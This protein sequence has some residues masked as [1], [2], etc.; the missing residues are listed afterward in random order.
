M[1]WQTTRNRRRR[2]VD[3]SKTRVV[4]DLSV[5]RPDRLSR[6]SRNVR[7]ELQYLNDPLKLADHV[8]ST[9]RERDEATAMELVRNATSSGMQCVVAWNHLIDFQMHQARVKAALATYNEMKKRGQTPDSHTFT[10]LLR[11]LAQN[12][13]YPAVLTKALSIY[14]SMRAPTA[15]IKPSIIHTNAALK[16]CARARDMDAMWSIA[17]DLPEHGKGAPDAWTWTT[18]LNALR[19]D[20]L[21]S[22]RTSSASSGNS[23]CN[24]V[25][26]AINH[27]RRMWVD[28]V[29]KWKDGK[30][31][32]DENLVCAMGR[33]LLMSDR[34][35]EWDE[36]L[37]LVEQT[38]EIARLVPRLAD[39]TPDQSADA[40]LASSEEPDVTGIAV[41]PEDFGGKLIKPKLPPKQQGN[42]P[43]ARAT[44]IARPSTN[45]ISLVISACTELQN[46][47]AA[48]AYWQLLTDSTSYGIE[49]DL[50]NYAVYL[51]L[52]RIMR[53][54]GEATEL[55]CNDMAPKADM[56]KAVKLFKIALSACA[57]DSNNPNSFGHATRLV[58]EL[59][60]RAADPDPS[61]LL[62]YM[63]L[64]MATHAPENVK[65]A[66]DR[67]G[68]Q[69][70]NLRSMLA[71]GSADDAKM[72]SRQVRE[73]A[74]LMAKHM[75]GGYM[76]LLP[77]EGASKQ[78][79]QLWE[80]EKRTLS[81]FVTRQMAELGRC[82]G[83]KGPRTSGSA[84]K[85]AVKNDVLVGDRMPRLGRLLAV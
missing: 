84:A 36:V 66:M 1:A 20:A 53:S 40:D 61:A 52:L 60:A 68:P 2:K 37:S 19:L 27:G 28:I 22:K 13:Q 81:A 77:M 76:R 8:R 62:T 39:E 31:Q 85:G 57:R 30:I 42:H 51:R 35:R 46:K 55:V 71:Y 69:F 49:P 21:A 3:W 29:G 33:I 82:E 5:Q 50:D 34:P 44:N 47:S 45:T 15:P 65:I 4:T 10:I 24:V 58:D 43:R 75:I 72:P 73:T 67:L 9:I 41:R 23:D 70:H 83:A 32:M 80:R 48:T 56:T 79:R 6:A 7:K 25:Y 78:E 26:K 17:A 59:V 11:G 64:A 74:L 63:D 16:V 54:S 14:H 12:T 38:M 18:I